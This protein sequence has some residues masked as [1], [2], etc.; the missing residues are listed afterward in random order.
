MWLCSGDVAVLLA[1]GWHW[2]RAFVAQLCSQIPALV[3]LYIGVAVS[4]ASEDAK[5]WI[6]CLT[7]GMFLYIGLSDVVNKE[8][9]IK[10]IATYRCRD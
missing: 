4:T 1:A 6:L 8:T 5:L 3:G 10:H 2:R 9:I 7:A